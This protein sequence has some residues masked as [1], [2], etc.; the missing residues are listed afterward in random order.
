M[1]VRIVETVPAPSGLGLVSGVCLLPAQNK[2]RGDHPFTLFFS[3]HIRLRGIHDCHRL[4]IE[5]SLPSGFDCFRKLRLLFGRKVVPR[6]LVGVPSAE[7][8][9]SMQWARL[10]RRNRKG[11]V[12]LAFPDVE[13]SSLLRCLLD[14]HHSF[15]FGR[16]PSSV[17]VTLHRQGPSSVML[18]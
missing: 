6:D 16:H 14:V 10:G 11:S 7:I 18:V 4:E 9:L 1:D 5:Y 8:K 15:S 12:F 17:S 2:A 13:A 3:D